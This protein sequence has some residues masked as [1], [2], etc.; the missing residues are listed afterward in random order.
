MHRWIACLF[1]T[2]LL[3]A[4]GTAAAQNVP[5]DARRHMAR[6]IAAIEMAKSAGDYVLAALEFEKAAKL[7]P[8]WPDVYYS[9]GSV[10]AKMGDPASA[11]KS[12][13][14]YLE[15]APRAPDAEKVRQEIYK[16]EYLRD[17]Q[18][19]AATLTGAWKASN[20]QTFKLLLDGPR[21][22]LARDEQQGDDV[23]TIS[24]LGSSHTG[25]MTDAPQPVFLG[26]LI[27]GKITGMYVQAA[28]KSSG[29]C[30]L[31][32]RKGP[33]E[34]TV[35]SAAGQMRIVYTRVT[36]EYDM[37]FKSILSD[38]LVCRQKDRKETPGYVLELKRL[39]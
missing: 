4:W 29:H 8:D 21:L 18:K 19:M 37:R 6:G 2:A 28:G 3:A 35:D 17:R 22:Q 24:A 27:E 32:E 31:P 10:Q 36:L 16:L 38:E 33:F 13:Q 1:L 5:E 30:D 25:E 9:L 23:I 34:G 14:R 12:Y 7:A 26:T 39:P 11:M 15:L 20:G